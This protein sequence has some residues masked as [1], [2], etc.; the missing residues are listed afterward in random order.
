MIQFGNMEVNAIMKTKFIPLLLAPALLLASCSSEIIAYPGDNNSALVVGQ[1]GAALSEEVYNNI[2]SIVY[3]AMRDNGTVSSDVLDEVLY[4]LAI[5]VVGEYDELSNVYELLEETSTNVYANNQTINDFINN[6]KAY[7][8]KDVDGNR[9]TDADSKNKEYILVKNMF[10]RIQNRIAE[11]FYSEITSGSYLRNGY[12]YETDYLMSLRNSINNVANPL[13]Q[14]NNGLLHDKYLIIPEI[15]EDEVFDYDWNGEHTLKGLLTLSLYENEEAGY[16]Y[17]STSIIPEIYRNLLVEQY[18]FDNN[19]NTLGRAYA[20]EVNIITIENRT[21]YPLAA[22]NLMNAYVDNYIN[23]D[24][25]T[26]AQNASFD[27]ISEA[28]RGVNLP[29]S[30]TVDGSIDE[31]AAFLLTEAGITQTS[32]VDNNGF[33][34]ETYNYFPGTS[35]GDMVEDLKEVVKDPLLTDSTIEN[36]FTNNG[37]YT[38]SQ[39][40]V[41]KTNVILQ[42]DY[43]TDGWYIR[44]GGLEDLGESFSSL[45]T[46]LF[47]IG[48]ANALDDADYPD[49][50]TLNEDNT[51]YTYSIPENEGN[52]VAKI[53]GRYFL[54]PV[55]RENPGD[56]EVDYTVVSNR[57]KDILWSDSDGNYTIVEITQAVSSSKLAKYSSTNYETVYGGL[58]G[59]VMMENIAHEVAS[60]IAEND[61]YRTLSTQYW[62]KA[63][64]LS[65]HDDVVYKYFADNYP[66]LFEE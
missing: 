51:T 1:N 46:R 64:T 62:L 17:V 19:Y 25:A 54:K 34:G 4:Q 32:Y 16:D 26:V 28:W 5:S 60:V 35:Y 12:F 61:S 39:G 7:W 31:Q 9:L 48:V 3:D 13:D 33:T 2:K 47:N 53:H 24:N 59:F 37:E 10:E 27:I 22:G 50:F 41:N 38:V 21:D 57:L 65:Y 49:R 6:H 44:N 55:T 29:A 11:A 18:L 66:E 36:E 58:D 8:V 42:E 43:V 45:R 56:V 40:I 63:A 20:R 52:Y 23:T 14:A 30:G 15:G